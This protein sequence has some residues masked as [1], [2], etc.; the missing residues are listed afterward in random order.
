[1]SSTCL[2]DAVAE[3]E[4]VADEWVFIAG[5]RTSGPSVAARTLRLRARTSRPVLRLADVPEY[6]SGD[7]ELASDLD[8]AADAS[9]R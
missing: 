4:P 6:G 1:M 5:R 8:Q 3:A 9:W 7:V 2:L